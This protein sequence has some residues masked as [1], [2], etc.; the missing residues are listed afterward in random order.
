MNQSNDC[1]ILLS[2]KSCRNTK[3]AEW[4]SEVLEESLGIGALGVT[5]LRRNPPGQLV[6]TEKEVTKI[7][8]IR[9]CGDCWKDYKK[10]KKIQNTKAS[11]RYVE[12]ED[13]D[14]PLQWPRP[15]TDGQRRQV[16]EPFPWTP[17][18]YTAWIWTYSN[19][20]QHHLTDRETT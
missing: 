20:S 12:V 17:P 13:E 5:E 2:L 7:L 4:S 6:N 8:P 11:V 1:E 18:C 9:Q 16:L 10:L 14:E 3:N 19:C 15:M